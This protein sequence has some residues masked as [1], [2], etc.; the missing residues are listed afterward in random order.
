MKSARNWKEFQVTR[1]FLCK[2]VVG[3][4]SRQG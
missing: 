3:G 1:W 2:E 4:E